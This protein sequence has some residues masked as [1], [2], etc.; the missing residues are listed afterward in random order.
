MNLAAD[1]VENVAHHAGKALLGS[2]TYKELGSMY[3][4]RGY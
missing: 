2:D 1:V 3:F 4:R